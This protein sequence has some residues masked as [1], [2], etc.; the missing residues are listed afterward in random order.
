MSQRLSPGVRPFS[1][2][3]PY[4]QDEPGIA[5]FHWV[6]KENE[7]PQTCMGHVTMEGPIHKTPGVHDEF[8]QV[9]LVYSGSGTIHLGDK[10]VRITEPSAVVIPHGTEHSMQLQEGERIRYVFVN[11]ILEE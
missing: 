8:D 6:L 10:S 2:L 11:R 3:E 4:E 7:I 1:A 9:Y 5:F